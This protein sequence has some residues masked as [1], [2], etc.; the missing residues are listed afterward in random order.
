MIVSGRKRY[1]SKKEKTP[2]PTTSIPA[3]AP[4]LRIKFDRAR[5]TK[6]SLPAGATVGKIHES[7]NV[8]LIA[9]S[10]RAY[11][12]QASLSKW[13]DV[14]LT[15][16]ATEVEQITGYYPAMREALDIFGLGTFTFVRDTKKVEIF[17]A[18]RR[19]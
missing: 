15:L 13:G 1:I 5:D 17:V 14:L 6:Y 9:L 8:A 11:F 16:A 3:R 10:C 4:H 19:S 12:S 7:L 2:V 18:A